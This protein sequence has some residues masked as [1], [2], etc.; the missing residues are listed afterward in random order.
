MHRV[1]F[2]LILLL[3]LKGV[4]MSVMSPAMHAMD[5]GPCP[6]VTCE[7]AA[8]EC[9]KHCLTTQKVGTSTPAISSTLFLFVGGALFVAIS[10]LV[11]R[12]NTFRITTLAPPGL[13]FVATTILRE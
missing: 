12:K 13:A 7:P 3:G 2:I 5:M 11:I 10:L 1:V 9:L 6:E 8:D 4:N